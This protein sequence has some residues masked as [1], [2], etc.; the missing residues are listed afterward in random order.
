MIKK[1]R[2]FKSAREFVRSL[3]LKNTHQWREYC[4]SIDKPEDIPNFPDRVYIDDGWLNWGDWLD[5]W[6][7]LSLLDKKYFQD[8]K[9]AREFV[10]KLGIKSTREW[11]DYCK[12][13]NKPDDIPSNPNI[14]YK[15]TGWSGLDDWLGLYWKD[16]KSA[17]EFVR[18]LGIKSTRE[19]ND[20]CK[21]GN[22]PDDIPANPSYHYKE[23]G[24]SGLDDWLG[25]KQ[26]LSF[27]EARKEARILSK[28]YNIKNWKDWQEAI[29]KGWIPEN[30]PV[31]PKYEYSKK[32]ITSKN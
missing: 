19:W 4:T 29:K 24:W 20:Y 23:T 9:S 32:K 18:K 14:I 10:R 16:F 25:I 31:N 15:E 5:V 3:K 22:K 7:D 13:G 1:Y 17:R 12:S 28:K 21:S 11:K 26:Y 30:I 27:K 8:F 6:G 2:D